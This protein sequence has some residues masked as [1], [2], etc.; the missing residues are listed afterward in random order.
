MVAPW[1]RCRPMSERGTPF[2][3]L[4]EERIAVFR[5]HQRIDELGRDVSQRIAEPVL[6][7]RTPTRVLASSHS[8]QLILRQLGDAEQCGRLHEH[9]H[10][11]FNGVDGDLAPSGSRGGSIAP[12]PRAAYR[13]MRG[14]MALSSHGEIAARL[15]T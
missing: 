5:T 2:T 6:E 15:C 4:A 10:V 7:R 1:S 12:P 8:H 9:L 14:S 11:W 3:S 13:A